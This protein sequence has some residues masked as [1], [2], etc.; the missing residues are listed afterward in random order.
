METPA[1]KSSLVII[2]SY[3]G[4]GIHKNNTRTGK[5]HLVHAAR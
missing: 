4:R 2:S 3:I 1:N 5:K